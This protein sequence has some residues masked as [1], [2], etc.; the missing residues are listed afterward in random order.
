MNKRTALVSLVAAGAVVLTGC[1]G[2]DWDNSPN[3]YK[4]SA[5]GEHHKCYYVKYRSEAE[6]LKKEGFC[7]KS[8]RMVAMP[9]GWLMMYSPYYFSNEYRNYYVPK[10]KW[11]AYKS[12]G[13]TFTFKHS[14]EIKKAQSKAT[15]TDN[16]GNKVKGNKVDLNKFG[17]GSKSKGGSGV[18]ICA[19]G[20]SEQVVVAIGGGR[21]GSSGGFG[22][23]RGGSRSG[24]GFGGSKGG[25][26]GSSGGFGGSGK[27]KSGVTRGGC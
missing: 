2:Y 13:T 22:G 20:A 5:F 27:A 4:P 11:S 3:C 6:R 23:S 24:S 16:N 10:S 17:G 15:Y 26:S 18:R 21:G 19:A 8:D 7:N 25:S 9:N 1:S 12:Y 14:S